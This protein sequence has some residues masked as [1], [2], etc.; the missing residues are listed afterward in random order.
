MPMPGKHLVSACGR[1]FI[2]I[3]ICRCT[4]SCLKNTQ[5]ELA[6]KFAFHDLFARPEYCIGDVSFQ[7]SKTLVGNRGGILDYGNGTYKYF[8]QCQSARSKILY[9]PLRLGPPI[10]IGGYLDLT[11]TVP[12]YSILESHNEIIT[13][14]RH[15]NTVDPCA[16]LPAMGVFHADMSQ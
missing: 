2:H 1:H 6:G 8:R 3:H 7:Q 14:L 15:P 11:H 10:C 12:L 4:A 5:R 9:R 13:F 16:A